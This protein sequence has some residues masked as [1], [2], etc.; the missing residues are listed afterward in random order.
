MEER[1]EAQRELDGIKREAEALAEMLDNDGGDFD[2][3]SVAELIRKLIKGETAQAIADFF[4]IESG[5]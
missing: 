3:D 1:M 4:E 5:V 2:T